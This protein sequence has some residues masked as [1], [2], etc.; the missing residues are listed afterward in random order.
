MKF[1]LSLLL[2]I[3]P[4][5]CYRQD[6][7]NNPDYIYGVGIAKTEAAA[8]SLAMLSMARA[9]YT[10]V[11]NETSMRV[12][13]DGVKSN[14]SY[15]NNVSLKT[16][17]RIV[18][19]KKLVNRIKR[20][21][22]EVYRYFNKKEYIDQHLSVYEYKRMEADKLMFA[23]SHIKNYRSDNPH[24]V[25]LVLGSL[26]T[27]YEAVNDTLLNL[28]YP[29]SVVLRETLKSEIKTV[30]DRAK[31]IRIW[32]GGQHGIM[33]K[34]N[35]NNPLPGFEYQNDKGEWVSP[36]VFKTMDEKQEVTRDD[37]KKRWAHVE[38]I[39]NNTAYHILYEELVDGKYMKIPVP[40]LFYF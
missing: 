40:D 17:I 19:S 37:T 21:E 28:L 30:Y 20:K 1:R 9:I 27:A 36:T 16:R 26:Y 35:N 10:D 3:L 12:H 13:S 33:A 14:R 2:L 4:M 32:D 8:D 39:V 38:G 15:D 5:L 25:N 22:Y 11:T 31:S 23:E 18:G 7:L 6:F 34:D 24:N 29:K